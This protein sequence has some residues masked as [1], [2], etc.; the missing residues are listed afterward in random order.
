[1]KG[2]FSPA[3]IAAALVETGKKKVVRPLSKMVLLAVLAG[4]FIGFAAHFATVVAVGDVAWYG[5]KK[6]FMGVAFS[7]GLMLV[8]IPG[9]ELFTG[10]CLIVIPLLEKKVSLG[11]MLKNWAVVYVG[12]FI[13]SI[14]LAAMMVYGTGLLTGSVG[15]TAVRIAAGK[16]GLSA[17]AVFFRGI[18][19]NWLV[20]LAVMMGMAS[21]DL[22]GRILGIFFPI[23]AFV[24]MGFE[25]SIA[26][27]YFLPAGI[28]AMGQPENGA[29]W[30]SFGSVLTWAAS[31]KNI[32]WATLGNIV[33]GGLFV[34]AVYW[35]TELRK[36]LKD[37]MPVYGISETAEEPEEI[38]EGVLV[39]GDASDR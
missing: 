26:N 21:K 14:L 16:A 35:F 1:M 29:L 4:V 23:M 27:M 36:P 33:G 12:N 11:G 20:C 2:F 25:H 28:M 39:G 7:L 10:N 24:A 8:M 5:I 34:G 31:A 19:A 15:E 6:L 30:E 22:T 38:R 9:A 3:E 37:R 13:G 17:G 18:G 32:L